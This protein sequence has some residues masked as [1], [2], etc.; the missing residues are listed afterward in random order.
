MKR[1][2][3]VLCAFLMVAFIAQA[4]PWSALA[5]V[6]H[7]LTA[8]ELAAAYALTGYTDGEEGPR[9]NGFSYHRGMKPN[10]TWNASQLSDY[11][12]EVLT[13]NLSNIESILSR[14]A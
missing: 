12:E 2:K 13:L 5:A 11:L 9:A 3:R 4:L 7:I 14:A 6:G 1:M 8:E 10:A